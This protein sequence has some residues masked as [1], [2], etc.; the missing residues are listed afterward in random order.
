MGYSEQVCC[1]KLPRCVQAGLL[2]LSVV[3]SVCLYLFADS[4]NVDGYWSTSSAIN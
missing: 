2:S 4:V 1:E 3:I